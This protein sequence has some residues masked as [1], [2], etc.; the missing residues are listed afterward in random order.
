MSL[1]PTTSRC[2]V[3]TL[4]SL[5]VWPLP[6]ELPHPASATLPTTPMWRR[7]AGHSYRPWGQQLC[8]QQRSSRWMTSS[9]S[10]PSASLPPHPTT[11]SPT[12]TTTGWP[13]SRTGPTWPPSSRLGTWRPS[14]PPHPPLPPPAPTTSSNSSPSMLHCFF[15]PATP[16][17]TPISPTQ[18][19]MSP[20]AAAAL[21][22][23]PMQAAGVGG[24]A[25]RRK[26]T[27]PL[28]QWRCTSPQ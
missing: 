8:P 19:P 27:S 12:T 23:F 4:Q 9:R 20:P 6:P 15:P 3:S 7:A 2:A 13:H 16:P 11:T 1:P 25:S 14:H 22:L 26:A 5:S 24:R 21:A 18:P 10:S 28:P 17:V